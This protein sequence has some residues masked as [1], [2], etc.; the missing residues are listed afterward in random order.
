MESA[1]W[2]R[3]TLPSVSFL[4]IFKPT[5]INFFSFSYIKDDLGDNGWL[6]NKE[7]KLDKPI[8]EY[9]IKHVKHFTKENLFTS[10]MNSLIFIYPGKV[11]SFNNSILLD[12][13]KLGCYCLV[14][15]TIN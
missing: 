4:I 13:L 1:L 15:N 9:G 2:L 6:S 7:I 3:C 10:M 12:A 14:E 8:T 5:W 11:N